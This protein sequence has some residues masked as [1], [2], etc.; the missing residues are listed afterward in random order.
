MY[1]FATPGL[2][3]ILSIF[4]CFLVSRMIVKNV[5]Y[6]HK[7]N[8]CVSCPPAGVLASVVSV[9]S[10]KARLRALEECNEGSLIFA[11]QANH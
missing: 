5:F 4:V 9:A 7:I 6:K 1:I 2:V 11:L 8:V 10:Y 3:T